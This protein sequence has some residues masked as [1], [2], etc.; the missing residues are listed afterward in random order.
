VLS[1]VSGAKPCILSCC[2]LIDG[3]WPN[4][5]LERSGVSMLISA[6]LFLFGYG[7]DCFG[8]RF[9]GVSNIEPSGNANID[10]NCFASF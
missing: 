8:M 6:K 4:L 9:S 5:T 1:N 7:V 2:E 10:S 3:D